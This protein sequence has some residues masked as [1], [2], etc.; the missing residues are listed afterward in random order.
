MANLGDMKAKIQAELA[1]ATTVLDPID[2]IREAIDFWQDRPLFF[3]QLAD[4]SSTTTTA[5]TANYAIPSNVQRILHVQLSWG[6]QNKQ[7][8]I[9]REWDWYL[10]VSRDGV[11]QAVP[12]GFYAIWDEQIWLWP[13]PSQAALPIEFYGTEQLTPY[14][15][16]NDSDDNAWTNEGRMLIRHWAKGYLYE[17][18]LGNPALAGRMYASAER[19]YRRLAG[20]SNAYL[21]RG[22]ITPTMF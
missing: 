3:N 13:T 22:E 5:G 10:E 4:T 2:A 18:T 8:L 19:E 15:L 1:V 14:P 7:P 20:R 12:S 9:R 6:G 21:G 17:H 11:L 16:T